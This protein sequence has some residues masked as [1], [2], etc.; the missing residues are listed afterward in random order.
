[1]DV[2]RRS[3]ESQALDTSHFPSLETLRW[4]LD[5]P[6]STEMLPKVFRPHIT[7]QASLTDGRAET[8]HVSKQVNALIASRQAH[9][10]RALL[11]SRLKCELRLV[12]GLDLQPQFPACTM[13]GRAA[14][15][16]NVFYIAH[17]HVCMRLAVYN[18][19]VLVLLQQSANLH[20]VSSCRASN[21][22]YEY[23][24]PEMLR[25]PLSTHLR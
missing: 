22:Q 1:M 20:S 10:S 11:P 17:R 18:G 4:R 24:S 9:W 8:F 13:L 19:I 25:S 7:L 2:H 21:A 23:M 14:R 12:G 3:R 6:I 15:A 5:V 16:Y